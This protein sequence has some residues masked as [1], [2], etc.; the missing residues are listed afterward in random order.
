M[1]SEP[2]P[3]GSHAVEPEDHAFDPNVIVTLVNILRAGISAWIL[4]PPG[5][6]KFAG[7][8]YELEI[9]EEQGEDERS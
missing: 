2:V 1:G 6:I 9:F 3:A 5:K 4:P 8:W 7:G